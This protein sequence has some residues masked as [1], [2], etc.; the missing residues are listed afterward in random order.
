MELNQ[1]VMQCSLCKKRAAAVASESGAFGLC[2]QCSFLLY[3]HLNILHAKQE[4]LTLEQAVGDSRPK[5]PCG[6]CGNREAQ[7]FREDGDFCIVCAK[8][9]GF[10]EA[11]KT[12]RRMGISAED[13]AEFAEAVTAGEPEPAAPVQQTADGRFTV[14]S[15]SLIDGQ[16]LLVLRDGATGREYLTNGQLSVFY[17]L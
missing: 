10:P 12:A 8:K 16:T 4:G 1:D 5:H 2:E 11:D 3:P 7:F 15:R 6:V 13:L 9:N 17:P 14:V